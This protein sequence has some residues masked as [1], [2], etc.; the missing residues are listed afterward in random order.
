MLA[1]STEENLRRA[2]LLLRGEPGVFFTSLISLAFMIATALILD[3]NHLAHGAQEALCEIA[4]YPDIDREQR[5]RQLLAAAANAFA[6]TGY[7]AFVGWTSKVRPV[8]LDEQQA[9]PSLQRVKHLGHTRAVRLGD[10]R[11]GEV[12]LIDLHDVYQEVLGWS[13]DLGY[14]FW[15]HGKDFKRA[16]KGRGCV[17]AAHDIVQS[18]HSESR[19]AHRVTDAAWADL[20]PDFLTL[21]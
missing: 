13:S 19:G 4:A 7:P 16:S 17:P 12:E 9:V 18:A 21:L 11:Y 3:R 5:D 20:T 1:P 10:A 2:L 14:S 15:I 6:M 8:A